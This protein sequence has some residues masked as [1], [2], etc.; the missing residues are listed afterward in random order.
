MSE[1]IKLLLEE[2]KKLSAVIEKHE[3]EIKELKDQNMNLNDLNAILKDENAIFRTAKSTKTEKENANLRKRN[4]YLKKELGG[5]SKQLKEWRKVEND[6]KTLKFN[7]EILDKK[8]KQK[9]GRKPKKRKIQPKREVPDE[10]LD[11]FDFS[12]DIL[13]DDDDTKVPPTPP[14]KPKPLTL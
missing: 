3:I 11:D 7:S 5:L 12:V 1:K 14:R 6:F 4:A 2:N 8:P 10:G 9:A 13:S